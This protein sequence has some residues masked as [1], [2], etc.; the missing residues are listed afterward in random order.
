MID[1]M[2]LCTAQVIT[3][4]TD[5]PIHAVKLAYVQYTQGNFSTWQYS[6]ILPTLNTYDG[7]GLTVC[8]G[9]WAAFKDGRRIS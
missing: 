5:D 8:C 3:Y 2:N 1:V 6:A 9:D 4:D 7:G